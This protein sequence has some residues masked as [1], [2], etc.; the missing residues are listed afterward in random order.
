MAHF[1]FFID[2]ENV[3][4]LIIGGGRQ[5]EQKLEKLLP[6][7]ARISIVAPHISDTIRRYQSEHTEKLELIQREFE[8]SD[9]ELKP[10][11]VIIALEGDKAELIG[12]RKH[13]AELCRQQNILVNSVDDRENC[14][15]FFPSLV[16]RDGITVGI[17]TGGTVPAR[18][19]EL[20]KKIEKCIDSGMF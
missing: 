7:G 19:V 13:I 16:K 20:R 3:R 11:F 5:A 12:Q 15:F 18:A 10:M 8:D 2:I 9:L 14:D 1:P 17:S 4:C 6:F